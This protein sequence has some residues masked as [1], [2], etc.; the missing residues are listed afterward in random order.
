MTERLV[1]VL[2][3]TPVTRAYLFGS[4]ARG[5]ADAKSDIDVMIEAPLFS[6]SLLDRIGLMDDLSKACGRKVDLGFRDS[7]SKY[8]RDHV[9]QEKVLF[10]ER[11]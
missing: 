10:Y 2:K 5:D 8:I 1:P 9:E 4:V 6:F 11:A 7:I 3:M